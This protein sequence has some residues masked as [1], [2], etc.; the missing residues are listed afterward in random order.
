M[1][2][3][4]RLNEVRCSI[5]KEKR[6]RGVKY[7]KKEGI[8]CSTSCDKPGKKKRKQREMK[9]E[10][11]EECYQR[12]VMNY[13]RETKKEKKRQRR[14]TD[15]MEFIEVYRVVVLMVV[16]RALEKKKQGNTN[17]RLREPTRT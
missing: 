4:A 15:E 13:E 2:S 6:G 16:R 14:E 17:V 10:G 7:K 5:Q 11:E 8:A 12:S 3:S 9:L 1:Y